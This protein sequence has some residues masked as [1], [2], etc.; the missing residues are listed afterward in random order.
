MK[1]KENQKHWDFSARSHK[2][3]ALAAWIISVAL[4]VVLLYYFTDLKKLFY[5]SLQN[6]PTQK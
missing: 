2:V 5:S 6:K 4:T 3:K 1:T